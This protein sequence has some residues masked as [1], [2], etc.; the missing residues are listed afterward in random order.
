MARAKTPFG[1]PYSSPSSS[2]S[3]TV[4]ATLV[5]SAI[6]LSVTPARRR[7]RLRL[8]PNACRSPTT[9]PHAAM[10]SR[11]ARGRTSFWPRR[12]EN[13]AGVGRTT[14]TAWSRPCSILVNPA[15]LLP[16][17]FALHAD[18]VEAEGGLVHER[19]GAAA[20]GGAGR[21]QLRRDDILAHAGNGLLALH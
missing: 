12:G 8:A 1:H 4:T 6:R 19:Y 15:G 14:K 10:F 20:A 5:S 7:A 16:G 9:A 2:D 17:A 3:H 21:A 18:E 11:R 13:S